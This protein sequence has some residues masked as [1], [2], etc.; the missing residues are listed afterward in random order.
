MRLV[1]GTFRSTPTSLPRLPVLSS[2]EPSAPRRMAAT[3]KLV[4]KI[5]KHDSCPIQPDIDPQPTI[6]TID[7]QEADVA[8]FANN[9]HQ[10]SMEA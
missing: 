9:W 7:I 1:S 3:D 5:A 8:G 6:A 4:E 10:K 2:I